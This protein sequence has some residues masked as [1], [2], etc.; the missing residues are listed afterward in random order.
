MKRGDVVEV[1]WAFSDQALRF[2][3]KAVEPGAGLDSMVTIVG[4]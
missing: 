4:D 1:D 2:S 3:A